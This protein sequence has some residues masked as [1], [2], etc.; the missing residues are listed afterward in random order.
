LYAFPNW[1]IIVANDLDR[2]SSHVVDDKDR[3]FQ[4]MIKLRCK[5]YRESR[6]TS[7]SLY[8][9]KGPPKYVGNR[10]YNGVYT[11][12]PMS[13]WH[14]S[15]WFPFLFTRLHIWAHCMIKSTKALMWMG[16]C[17]LVQWSCSYWASITLHELQDYNQHMSIS[18]IWATL[19]FVS[20]GYK[21]WHGTYHL[22]EQSINIPSAWSDLPQLITISPNKLLNWNQIISNDFGKIPLRPFRMKQNVNPIRPSG[23]MTL[24]SVGGLVRPFRRP[25]TCSLKLSLCPTLD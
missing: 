25:R 2:R 18:M 9:W 4:F 11:H 24:V 5:I 1:W 15:F 16:C 17:P 6:W 12:S 21:K 23:N 14:M 20:R 19:E 13:L 22:R 10:T 3:D 8:N 7:L